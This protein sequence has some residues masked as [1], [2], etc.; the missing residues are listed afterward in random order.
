MSIIVF[1]TD[2]STMRGFSLGD[3]TAP[4]ESTN[5]DMI[6]TD[7]VDTTRVMAIPQ[8]ALDSKI[9]PQIPMGRFGKPEE[10][11]G[12]VAFLA[13]DEAAFLIGANTAISS[14]Q[15]MS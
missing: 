2:M 3:P 4:P 11:A 8:Y 13:S 12:L 1:I 6:A 15:Y 10:V 5:S 9:I 14:G 7:H